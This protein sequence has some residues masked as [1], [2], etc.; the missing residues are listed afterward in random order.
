M[1]PRRILVAAVLAVALTAVSAAAALAG[2]AK[3]PAAAR[4]FATQRF[5]RSTVVDN[6][7]FPLKPGMRLTFVGTT[8]EGKRRIPRRVVST[9]T[10]LTKTIAGVATIAIW[11]LDY[12]DGELEEAEIAFF[13]QDDDGN[14]WQLGE[15]P[16]EYDNGAFVK[17]PAWLAGLKGARAGIAM[18][19]TPT[20]GTPSYA[21][22]FA[23]PPISWT[24][25]A[26]V[27]R[28]GTR[29]CVPAGCFGKV[30]ITDEFSLDQP[31]RHQLKYYAPGL[32]T[33]RVGWTG[34]R[35]VDRET[36]VL[37]AAAHLGPAA[38][39]RVRTAVLRQE[40]HAYAIS[41]DVYGRTD[42]VRRIGS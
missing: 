8:S 41:K 25:R 5:G 15:Y 11:E 29:T 3:G 27:Y 2:S 28:V 19:A 24:D 4:D 13:A 42:P 30:L 32:G 22:G 17:A 18:Q 26:R 39:A 36:L 16:E 12:K 7:W 31:G 23:P 9:V 1:R 33:V 20:P 37:V 38:L 35:E 34:S 10:D 40:R 6:R 14:V 21:Q